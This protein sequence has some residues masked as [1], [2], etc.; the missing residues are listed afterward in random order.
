M[1]SVSKFDK[2]AELRADIDGASALV[3]LGFQ[4]MTVADVEAL[5]A[6]M[7]D[8]GCK[9]RVY[10]NTVIQYAIKDTKHAALDAMLAGQL[11]LAYHPEDPGAPARVARDFAK[12]ND[13]L[14][15]VGGVMEGKALD[16]NGVIA[17]ANMPGPLELKAMFLRLLN[18]PATNFVRVLN[19]PASSFLNVLNAKKDKDAA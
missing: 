13:K 18:T 5:R 17:L 4:G 19:A 12:E 2:S 7:R 11:A 6:K 15:L 10:K 16:T 9:Y 14:K 1:T 8:S 3:L